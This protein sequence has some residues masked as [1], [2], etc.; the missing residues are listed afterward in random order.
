MLE[1][2][3]ISV[4]FDRPVLKNISL[5]AKKGH[6]I[7]LVGKSGAG[8]STLLNVIS[9]QLGPQHGSITL[10][11]E[12]LPNAEQLLVPGYEEIKLVSQ[13]Y[14]LDPYH[15][16]EENIREAAISLP[17]KIKIRRVEELLKLLKLNEIRDIKANETSGGE[18]QRLSIARAIALRPEVLLLDEPFS[19]LDSQLRA[20]LFKYILKLRHEEQLTI[21]LVS[22]EGQDV[23]GLSDA[24]YFLNNGK[25]SPRKTPYNA[26]YQLNHL[27]NAKLLGIVNQVNHD[28][29]KV[30]F[31]PDEYQVA[32]GGTLA[33]TFDY[34]IF[35][36]TQYLNYFSGPNQELIILSSIEPFKANVQINISRKQKKTDTQSHMNKR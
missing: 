20:L 17:E 16:V 15:T 12:L 14:N 22:H 35:L 9:G 10:D 24:I 8:K 32:V 21:I 1:I 33:L 4:N 23:L 5:T 7:G 26:Y 29:L 18:Q 30:R 28:G 2:K 27:G 11:N 13:D 6:I 36:G 19:N 25:L 3:E 34:F 31:R